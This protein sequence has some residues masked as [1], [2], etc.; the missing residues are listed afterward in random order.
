VTGADRVAAALQL[1]K[2]IPDAKKSML[3]AAA[4]RRIAHANHQKTLP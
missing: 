2:G 3:E 4:D 1:I